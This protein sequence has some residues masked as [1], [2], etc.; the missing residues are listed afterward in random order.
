MQIGI[1]GAGRVGQAVAMRLLISG[2]QV[3]L[4]NSAGPQ[5]LKRV[6]KSLGKGAHVGTVR[7]AAAYGEV[8]VVAIPSA[9][10]RDLPGW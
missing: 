3:M 10:G 4:S 5:S 8:V 9:G 6:E 1:I 2:H 7:E